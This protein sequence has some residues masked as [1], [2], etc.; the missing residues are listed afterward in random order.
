MCRRWF[1]DFVLFLV[2]WFIFDDLFS[3]WPIDDRMSTFLVGGYFFFLLA[4]QEEEPTLD[5]IQ[6]KLM[7]D[8]F[9]FFS[10]F[11]LFS[12]KP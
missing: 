9:R 10:F 12:Q 3:S 1:F 2:F 6:A 4:G 5:D 8:S 7:N 11:W